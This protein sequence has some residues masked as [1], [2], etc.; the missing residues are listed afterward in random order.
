[1]RATV[2]RETQGLAAPLFLG[3]ESGPECSLARRPAGDLF[4]PGAPPGL[5]C[6]GAP[7]REL[8]SAELLA[9]NIFWQSTQPAAGGAPGRKFVFV[10]QPARHFFS[11]SGWR[12]IYFGAVGHRLTTC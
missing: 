8:I 3:G 10:E 6:G 4:W 2:A 5:P 9:C 7:G 11:Q 12:E 1:M